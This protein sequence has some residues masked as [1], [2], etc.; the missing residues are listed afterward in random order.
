MLSASGEAKFTDVMERALYNGINSGMSLD[1]KLYCYRNPLAFEPST[2]DKIRNPWYDT[3]CCPPNLE[4]TFAALPG[5]F[6][7]TSPDGVYVHFYDNSTL[8]WKL[9]NGTKLAIKQTT[10]YP[11]EGTVHLAVSLATPQEF[12]LFVRIPGWSKEN[13]VKVNGRVVEGATPGQY[14]PIKRR[15]TAG[16]T[17]E[18]GFDMKPQVVHANIA[19]ADD[20]GRIALQRGPIVYCME[21]MDQPVGGSESF[22]RYTAHLTETTTDHY[23]PEL[24]EG[25]VVL[26]HPGSWLPKET[27][28]LYAETLPAQQTPQP[29]TLRL[30]PYY[31]WSNRDLSAM[32]VWIPYA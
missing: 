27:E 2:G 5:Y 1:G 12:T 9:E 11:W 28:G 19:V 25:V 17:V 20:R 22:A 24:L 18:L 31:A 13:S 7:S 16:D 30:I 4:R 10:H 21:Q 3:T 32:Q 23:Q 26:E 29:A 15:W 14:L 8:D 6:Y